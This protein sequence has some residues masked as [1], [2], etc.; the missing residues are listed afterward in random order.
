MDF[1]DEIKEFWMC[2]RKIMEK[3]LQIHI[4][5]KYMLFMNLSLWN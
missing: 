2:K 1:I 5:A 3:E 4:G